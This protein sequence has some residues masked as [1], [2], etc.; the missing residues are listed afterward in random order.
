MDS[1]KLGLAILFPLRKIVV[2]IDIRKLHIIDAVAY[3]IWRG[4]L[5]I[6]NRMYQKI[7]LVLCAMR[8]VSTVF[9]KEVKKTPCTEYC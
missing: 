7:F 3:A 1:K 4:C 8:K 2:L 5:P 9:F 6:K